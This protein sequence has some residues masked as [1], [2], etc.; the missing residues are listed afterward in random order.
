MV[1]FP[2]LLN[3]GE[4]LIFQGVPAPRTASPFASQLTSTGL[5]PLPALPQRPAPV[6]VPDPEPEPA[7]VPVVLPP[8]LQGDSDYM[9][10]MGGASTQANFGFSTATDPSALAAAEQF[11]LTSGTAED[12]ASAYASQRADEVAPMQSFSNLTDVF[13]Q[14]L[15]TTLDQVFNRQEAIP[16]AILGMAVPGAGYALSAMANLNEQNQAYN[17]AMAEMGQPGYGYG[18][19]DGQNFSI[20]PGLVSGSR[21]MSGVVPEF[22][23]IDAFDKMQSIELG[24]DPNTNTGIEAT[25]GLAGYNQLGEYVDEFGNVA[26]M[27]S[28]EDLNA[29]AQTNNITVAQARDAL[30][31]AREGLNSLAGALQQANPS[32]FDPG[33][34]LGPSVSGGRGR[35]PTDVELA[36]MRGEQLNEAGTLFDMFSAAGMD[37]AAA[38]AAAAESLGYDEGFDPEGDEGFY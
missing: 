1:T 33:F 10:P 23:D 7:P 35:G 5:L 3:V 9:D 2:S 20:S 13:S 38:S 25:N 37:D 19:I 8:L 26:A 31:Q 30:N 36:E 29:L 18:T 27:G 32:V 24:I 17:R 21:V 34:D 28:M 6:V 12:I 4:P 15:S 11:G 22:F 16:G 14:P